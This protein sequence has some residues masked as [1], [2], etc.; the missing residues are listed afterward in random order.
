MRHASAGLTPSN[1]QRRVHP[2][3][4]VAVRERIKIGLVSF[5]VLFFAACADFASRESGETDLSEFE[6]SFAAVARIQARVSFPNWMARLGSHDS[7]LREDHEQE[8]LLFEKT[9]AMARGLQPETCARLREIAMH[10]APRNADPVLLITAIRL[11]AAG[12]CSS[13]PN[14]A[15]M[16][17]D[18]LWLEAGYSA[19]RLRAWVHDAHCEGIALARRNGFA[20]DEQ[21]CAAVLD[22]IHVSPQGT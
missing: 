20:E 16:T 8:R 13:M 2:P 18:S 12:R 19:E 17:G 7:K 6:T 21:Q 11:L 22:R 14:I 9:R 1:H 4:R 5:V 10:E 15:T 3:L